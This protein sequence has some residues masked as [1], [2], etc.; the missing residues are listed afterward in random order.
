[1]LDRAHAATARRRRRRGRPRPRTRRSFVGVLD[2][3]RRLDAAGDVDRERVRDGDRL[4]DVV[5]RRARRT[6]SAAPS[7]GGRRSELP[8]ER[9]AGA[10][11]AAPAD[12]A[13]EQVEVGVERPRAPGCRRRRATRAALITLQPVRRAA[14]VQNAGPSSPCSCSMAS[15]RSASAVGRDLVERRVDEHADELDAAP[16]RGRRSRPPSA[17][18][19][20]RGERGHRIIPIAQAPS[21]TASSASS[22]FVMPQIFA[23]VTRT[24]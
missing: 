2:A 16:Q 5:G 14:S 9:L 13:V 17:G 8:V 3:G 1:M 24:S 18:S 15:G 22:R 4:G 6:G 23:R 10:A 19:H 11:A 20:A 21:A 12:V 7:R